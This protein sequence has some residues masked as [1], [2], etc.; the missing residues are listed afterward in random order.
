MSDLSVVI[1]AAGQGTRMK[2]HLTKVLH[3]ICGRPLL[4]YS[5]LA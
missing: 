1:L 5:L 2:S 4:E 3:E